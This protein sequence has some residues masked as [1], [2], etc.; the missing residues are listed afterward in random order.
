[1]PASQPSTLPVRASGVNQGTANIFDFGSGLTVSLVNGIATVTSGS[2]T[3]N[4]SADYE[5]A[6]NPFA[7]GALGGGAD[8]Y[9]A[10]ASAFS[11]AVN[12]VNSTVYIPQLMYTSRTIVIPTAGFK[13]P[14][15]V[16]VN[17]GTSVITLVQDPG[18]NNGDPIQ[19]QGAVPTGITRST[20]Y[21]R[22][23]PNP[24]DRTQI[25]LYNTRANALV[26]GATGKIAITA[27]VRTTGSISSGSRVLTV[28]SE[29]SAEVGTNVLI[30][31]T[32]NSTS[33]FYV[34]SGIGTGTLNLNVTSNNTASSAT[35]TYVS[36]V[37]V[38]SFYGGLK[39]IFAPGAGLKKHPTWT[40]AAGNPL[41]KGSVGSD[42]EIHNG[43]F[44]G[45]SSQFVPEGVTASVSASNSITS[46]VTITAGST[47]W[48]LPG[49]AF[50]LN[51]GGTT[52]YV[53]SVS[54][55]TIT[56]YQTSRT[57]TVSVTGATNATPIVITTSTAHNLATGT[58]VAITGVLGNTAANGNWTI[59]ST[60]A[61]T[62][63]LD[64]SVGNG[65]YT[66]G[67][68]VAAFSWTAFTDALVGQG[69]SSGIVGGFATGTAG[70]T[71]ATANSTNGLFAGLNIYFAG[72]ENNPHSILTVDSGTGVITF[73][74]TLSSNMTNRAFT[75]IGGD[76]GLELSSVARCVISQCKFFNFGDAALRMQSNVAYYGAASTSNPTGGVNTLYILAFH[77]FF[78]NCYQTSTTTNNFMEGGAANV[79]FAYNTF[80]YLRGSVK[81][82]NRVPGSYNIN[83]MHNTILSSHNHG[84]ECDSIRD[85][86]ILY[87]QITNV[88]NQG[89]FI[90]VNNGPAG[91]FGLGIVGFP[92]DGLQIEGN[93][94]DNCGQIGGTACIRMAPD[95]YADGT[96]FNYQGV[97]IARN[98]IKN[99]SNTANVS[100]NFVNG[101]YQGLKITD[102][103][104]EPTYLGI[105]PIKLSLRS[106]TDA[107][108][109]NDIEVKYNTIFINHASG[110]GIIVNGT[111][112]G[113]VPLNDVTIEGNKIFGTCSSGIVYQNINNLRIENNIQNIIGGSWLLLNNDTVTNMTLRGN[114]FITSLAFGFSLAGVTNAQI[115]DNV[116]NV[117]SGSTISVQNSC[118]NLW[119]YNNKSIG[120]TPTYRQVPVNTKDMS[121]TGRREDG[122]G[123]PTTGTWTAGDIIDVT[124]VTLPGAP[125]QYFCTVSGTADTSITGSPTA[126]TDGS[127]NTVTFSSLAAIPAR[128]WINIAGAWSGAR[129][130]TSV[131]AANNTGVVSGAVPAAVSSAAVT[132][133]APAFVRGAELPE[134]WTTFS[135]A[136]YTALTTDKVIS[137]IG[138]LSAARAVTL[139]LAAN[140]PAGY[141]IIIQDVSGTVTSPNALQVAR[142][143]SDTI[144]GASTT[145]NIQK[146]YG[147]EIYIS[148]GVSN[149][150]TPNLDS[151]NG[152]TF[153]NADYSMLVTDRQILQIGTLSAPRT[154][155]L[156]AAASLPRG[157]RVTI[158]DDS[159]TCTAA[160][161]IIIARQGS[162]GIHGLASIYLSS[163]WASVVL[164]VNGSNK[165]TIVSF[166]LPATKTVTGAYVATPSDTIILADATSA[167]FHVTL[168]TSVNRNGKSF[169]VK[170][171]DSSA[172]VVTIDTTSSQTIDGSTTKAISTQNESYTVNSDN[173]NWWIV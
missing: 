29:L 67:G 69:L 111:A 97:S 171:I 46:A 115:T 45:L 5:A 124:N 76:D 14:Y 129:Q 54:G 113:A 123:I 126:T 170:K 79:W 33:G 81:F 166:A 36:W 94:F 132:Y 148:D 39:V 15:I 66:S 20:Q 31:G 121:K 155:T 89:I 73:T 32:S 165:W 8:D 120:G 169:T 159:G 110:F 95:S 22:Y 127:T 172:N 92:I 77:N 163:P 63:S 98:V 34:I 24:A 100:F 16:S 147:R 138:T 90:L 10:L 103:I 104:W 96:L 105:T 58:R 142:N 136:N 48:A 118:S 106:N 27:D 88:R 151:V 84:F 114:H 131:N 158:S 102:N 21:Y 156:V 51:G 93:I 128:C 133:V 4:T 6:Y 157:T 119:I 78:R 60:G 107:A 116:W 75:S 42:I 35:V 80:E 137:Q 86:K 83:I 87:N 140:V 3:P 7:H 43:I 164:E 55:S 101:S 72:D 149:W 50:T 64:T 44:E 30:N 25:A 49:V 2:A 144:N 109:I 153:S 167:A 56:A 28:A 150:T 173:A 59:T 130:V 65:A 1:M 122:T 40:T 162:D 134:G 161:T 112:G 68:T 23:F 139:P 135:N 62:L 57:Q 143:G 52:Y 152:V 61:N 85:L 70:T 74:N 91:S 19:F 47:E 108:F 53:D 99:I 26:G 146:P 9:T 145:R 41:L 18:G 154:V 37:D 17:T 82:A 160:N 125:S 12:T 71:T 38:N 141:T 168:P 11:N 13:L 117:P